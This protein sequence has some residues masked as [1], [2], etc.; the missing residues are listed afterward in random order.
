MKKL[1]MVMAVVLLTLCGQNTT[2]AKANDILNTRGTVTEVQDGFIVVRDGTDERKAVR[3]LVLETTYV[4]D[5]STTKKMD[6]AI[7]KKGD[8]VS[9]FY[10]PEMTKSLPPQAKGILLVVGEE[11]SNPEYIRVSSVEHDGVNIKVHYDNKIMNIS[12]VAM[13]Y[14]KA[15]RQGDEV[16][17]WFTLA[18]ATS[19]NENNASRAVLLN[20]D[21]VDIRIKGLSEI[22]VNGDTIPNTV[23]HSINGG[24]YLPLRAI[25]EKLGYTVKWNP[26]TKRIELQNGVRSA[27]LQVGSKEYADGKVRVVLARAP[28]MIKGETLVPTEFFTDVLGLEVE[29]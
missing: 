22:Q 24:K 9:A 10:S 23:T 26:E 4:I 13:K 2:F 14:N 11:S 25:S 27:T 17:A 1:L 15:I 20:R 28:I 7:I 3:V 19:E 18:A 5:N 6:H 8:F 21:P 12:D 16:L 29:I